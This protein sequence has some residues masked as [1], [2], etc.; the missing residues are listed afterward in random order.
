MKSFDEFAAVRR[1]KRSSVEA[2]EKDKEGEK[3]AQ[4]AG[5]GPEADA[6]GPT[7]SPGWSASAFLGSRGFH[8]LVLVLL[9][10]QCAMMPVTLVRV[11]SWLR[12]TAELLVYA[13]AVVTSF[14]FLLAGFSVD[15]MRILLVLDV[16]L[17][18]AICAALLMRWAR[19]Y[20][21]LAWLPF[22]R[23]LPRLLDA[24]GELDAAWQRVLDAA[25]DE[26]RR[27]R[28]D[29]SEL[30]KM[31]DEAAASLRREDATNSR[32]KEALEGREEEVE[33]LQAA[34]EIAAQQQQQ[35]EDRFGVSIAQEEA[36]KEAEARSGPAGAPA[37]ALPRTKRTKVVV[38]ADLKAKTT[39]G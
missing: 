7:P 1:R 4:A 37:A 32:L 20:P 5:A 16:L 19:L 11:A 35:W 10:V 13:S 15:K 8:S 2:G 26:G 25:E 34:L 17:Q 36:D 6:D 33:M 38:G 3:P 23:A 27:W 24:A 21:A 12:L 31:L 9:L 22:A 30:R 14:E 28:A 29:A 39:K 18:T